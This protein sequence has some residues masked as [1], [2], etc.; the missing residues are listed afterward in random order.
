M[1]C[2]EF[3]LEAAAAAADDDDDAERAQLSRTLHRNSLPSLQ[4]IG[5]PPTSNP[6]ETP[7]LR[8]NRGLLKASNRAV[9]LECEIRSLQSMATVLQNGR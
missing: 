9:P 1:N 8:L 4:Q 6:Q 5:H 3:E 7:T 2:A